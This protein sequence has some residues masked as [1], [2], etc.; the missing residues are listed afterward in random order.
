M[1]K[2][3]ETIAPAGAETGVGARIKKAGQ[4]QIMGQPLEVTGGTIGGIKLER[5]IDEKL[6]E[7]ERRE[8]IADIKAEAKGKAGIPEFTTDELNAFTTMTGMQKSVKRIESY[9]KVFPSWD[10]PGSVADPLARLQVWARMDPKLKPAMDDLLGMKS[11][12]TRLK[13]KGV[14]TEGDVTRNA[15]YIDTI[16]FG[17]PKEKKEAYRLLVQSVNETK[18]SI[19]EAAVE[20]AKLLEKVQAGGLQPQAGKGPEKVATPK[21]AIDVLKKYGL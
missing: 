15:G 14:L 17:N 5:P 16:A 9:M 8:K 10:L 13:E 4:I 20:R 19:L 21:S 7:K 12:L 1:G 6:K 11:Q 18:D 3:G 2:Y